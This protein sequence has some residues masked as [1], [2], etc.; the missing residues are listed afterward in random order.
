MKAKGTGLL[1]DHLW[2]A[3][4]DLQ[5]IGR[6]WRQPQ[7]KKVFVYRFLADKTTDMV[8]YDICKICVG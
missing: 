4:E 3:M 5:L 6:C 8:L 1:Q 2:S 7:T